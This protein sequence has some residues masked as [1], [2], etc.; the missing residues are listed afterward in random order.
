MPP[1]SEA[2][3]LDAAGSAKKGNPDILRGRYADP[4]TSGLRAQVSKDEAN[5]PTFELK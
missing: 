4:N 1:R 2:N 5:A 3:I